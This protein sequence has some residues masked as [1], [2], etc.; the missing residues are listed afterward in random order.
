MDGMLDLPLRLSP[1]RVYRFYRGGALLDAFRGSADPEDNEFPED[2]VGST[3]PAIN[4]PDRSYDGEGLSTVEIDGAAVTLASL[5][6]A[7]PADVAG[8]AVVD[9]Y[10]TT[11]AL[12][13]KLLDAG[14]RLPVHGHPTRDFARHILDSQFG[15][16]EAWVI[17]ATRQIPGAPS[18]RVWLGFRETV[19]RAQ[20]VDWI[21]RQDSAAI[22]GAMN[23]IEAHPG[24][25]FFVSPGLPHAT[26]AGVFLAEFQEPTDFSIV[27]EY[28][29]FPITPE[30]AHL[31]LGWDVMLDCFR[32]EAL[33]GAELA[34]HCP[35]PTRL[36]SDEAAGWHLDDLLG[37][38]SH[39][40][41]LARKLVVKG[42]APWPSEGIYSVV[43]VT[44]G[45]GTASTAHGS[46]DIK[47]GDTFAVFGGTAPTTISGDVEMMVASPGLA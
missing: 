23:E 7:S 17:L 21:D 22:L 47:S 32:R 37:E 38:Q 4:P 35:R 27:A 1:N 2:W 14:T 26:G 16:A 39:P 3:T 42:T 12:L 44:G 18:P 46:L 19:E 9:R 8:Q 31:G 24:D 30:E 45:S 25:A 43:I 41:F 29:G 15:K 33:Q 6:E 36:A 5:L 13:V 11:T 10:G 28:R 20:L 34:A 40:F